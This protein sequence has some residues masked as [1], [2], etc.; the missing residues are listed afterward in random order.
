MH[1]KETKKL[2]FFFSV[3][4]TTIYYLDDREHALSIKTTI[5]FYDFWDPCLP[6]H[7]ALYISFNLQLRRIQNIYH[8]DTEEH[9]KPPYFNIS[10]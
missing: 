3:N 8:L 1:A 6:K 2:C 7:Q 10:L 9:I 5:M 4:D